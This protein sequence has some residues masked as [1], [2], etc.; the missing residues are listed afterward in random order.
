[1]SNVLRLAIVDPNDN[2]RTQLKNMLLGM[3]IV[4]LEAECSRYEFFADVISQT[5]PDIGVIAID[6]NAERGLQLV[7]DVRDI[8]PECALL[9]ISTSTDGQLILRVMRGGAKEFLTQPVKMEDMIAALDRISAA[10]FGT[11]EGRGRTCHVIAVCGA[12]GGVGSTSVAVNLGC[13]LARE[14]RNSVVLVD[15]ESIAPRLSRLAE[16]PNRNIPENAKSIE[17]GIARATIIAARRLPKNANSTAITNKPP[18]N[19]LFFTVRM[20]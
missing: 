14:E 13:I 5:K 8:A 3:D 1:M 2:S 20:T 11:G 16:M 10:K 6:S 15:L 4:W 18:S 7:E 19:R 12:T 9:V 17:S